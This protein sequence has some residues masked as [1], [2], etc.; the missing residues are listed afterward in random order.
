MLKHITKSLWLLGFAVVIC[1][2]VY[3]GILWCIGQGLFPFQANGSMVDGSGQAMAHPDDT[4]VGSL[5]IAQPFTKDE[6]FQP[7]PSACNYDA[8]ASASQAWAASNYQLRNRVATQLG[9][10]VV[11]ASGAKAGQPVAP[12]IEAWFQKDTFGGQPG[13]VAQ[14]ADMHSN[15]SFSNLA[16]QWVVP[17]GSTYDPK[18]PTP[19]QQYVLDWEKTHADVVAKFKADNPS[20]TD[21]QP[22]DLAVVFFETFSKENPGK[23]PSLVTP[24]AATQ[25]AGG[26]APA[27]VMMPVNTGNDIQSIFFDMW[28][29]DH[30]DAD[31]QDVPGDL[32]TTSGSGLDP[33]ITLQN[34]EYQLDRVSGKWAADLKRDP[35]T[36]KSEIEQILEND[37]TAPFGGIAGEKIVNVLQ[38]NLDLKNKYGS[39]S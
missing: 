36:V 2:I 7:R 35:A 33:H 8:S 13:I 1:C 18:N 27:Q 17:S 37:S 23:F 16:Q 25:P 6:Y 26:A 4:A 30:P 31:L 14:W 21:P 10:I 22:A 38:V 39:P 5:L 34:A 3:P 9:P 24:P 12:D 28:R 32:V 11:Y 15:S 29:Q 20:I 19:Q